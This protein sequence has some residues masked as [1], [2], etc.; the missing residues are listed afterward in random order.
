MIPAVRAAGLED[1]VT[2]L[3]V[4]YRDLPACLN[5]RFDKVVSV[6]MIE[7]VGDTYL[8][9]YF[10]VCDVMTKPG[11]RML[12]Q[13]IV[14]ADAFYE[15]YRRSVDVI[16]RYIFP[17]GFLPSRLDLE[18]R[19][20]HNTTFRVADVHDITDHYP[21]TLRLWH[22]GLRRSWSRLLAAGY[23]LSLLR[24]W[25]YYFC[26]CEGGFLEQT[27]GDLQLLLTKPQT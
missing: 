14:I 10:K 2:V 16:Q 25:E 24:M 4:D 11:G 12:L 22:Q 5:R 13:S 23:P 27:V 26:Y 20:A 7:A 21:R 17:G 9:R 6:E 8:G 18:R 15:A 3:N 1:R 19:I